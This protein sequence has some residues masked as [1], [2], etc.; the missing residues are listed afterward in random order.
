VVQNQRGHQ[1]KILNFTFPRN[2]MALNWS[3]LQVMFRLC[4][5]CHGSNNG[6]QKDLPLATSITFLLVNKTA[7]SAVDVVRIELIIWDNLY[8]LA[9]SVPLGQYRN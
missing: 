7:M 6:L 9:N 8:A 2:V 4:L 3:F 1:G 5:N